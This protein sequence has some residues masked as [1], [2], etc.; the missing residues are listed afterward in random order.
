M[1]A[2]LALNRYVPTDLA[3]NYAPDRVSDHFG[4]VAG[5]VIE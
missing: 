5:K 2:F 1:P 4:L 3:K